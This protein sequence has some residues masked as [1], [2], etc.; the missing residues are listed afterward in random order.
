MSIHSST[1]N[2]PKNPAERRAWVLYQLRLR[3]WHL[4]DIAREEGVSR[5]AVF[6][7]LHAPNEH[8]EPAIAAKLGLEAKQLFPERFCADTGRRL[9]RTRNRNRSTATAGV[10]GQRK[11]AH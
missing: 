2:V 7:A 4:A 6:S 1:M 8:L 3:G 11:E 10:H 9:H 5:Q